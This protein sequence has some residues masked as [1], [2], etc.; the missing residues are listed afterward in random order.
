MGSPAPNQQVVQFADYVL[1][2]QTAELRRN[3]TKIVLQDQ[4]FQILTTLIES[5]GR[6]VLREELIRKLWPNG[7]FVD[8]EQSS[9][10]AIARLRESLCDDAEHPRFI[11]TLPRKGY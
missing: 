4:P 3:G 11:E 8:F 2:L 10:R 7:T 5:P 6:L 9:N 1:N